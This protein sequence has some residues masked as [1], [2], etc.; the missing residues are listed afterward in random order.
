[1]EVSKS[2][3]MRP[4][5]LFGTVPI[6]YWTNEV[7]RDPELQSKIW[8]KEKK[9]FLCLPG[10]EQGFMGRAAFSPITILTKPR[11]IVAQGT[12]ED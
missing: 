12:K 7:G 11:K 8:Q 4:L 1:M 3:T 2:F 6:M 5:Y 10:I 9:I